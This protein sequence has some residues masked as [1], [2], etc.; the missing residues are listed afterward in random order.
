MRTLFDLK[1]NW[2]KV[3]MFSVVPVMFVFI[4][5]LYS[6][7][8]KIT[9]YIERIPEEGRMALFFVFSVIMSVTL[10]VCVMIGFAWSRK[11]GL[12]GWKMIS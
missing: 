2:K 7:R 4:Y 12:V 8:I 3:I 9:E 6:F 11:Y 1:D 5:N 10:V